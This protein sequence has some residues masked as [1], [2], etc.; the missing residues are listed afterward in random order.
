MAHQHNTIDY[1]EFTVADMAESKAFYSTVFDWEFTDYAPNYAGIKGPEKE[2][3][4]FSVG[5]VVP[6]GVL[7]VFY[8]ENLDD[9]LTSVT[10]AGGTITKPIFEFPGGR[11]FH[12]TDPSGNELAIWGQPV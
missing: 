10:Q 9:S 7:I 12:F 6:G 1:L 5:T 11:R 3:G 8:S 2:I 4:G